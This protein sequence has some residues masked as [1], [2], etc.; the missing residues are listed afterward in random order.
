MGTVA[1]LPPKKQ[2][3]EG[4]GHHQWWQL[5]QE[6]VGQGQPVASF[7]AALF[8]RR[9]ADFFTPVVSRGL[10]HQRLVR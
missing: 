5:L 6:S 3:A 10:A 7:L 8:H 4:T 1:A 9:I 2:R